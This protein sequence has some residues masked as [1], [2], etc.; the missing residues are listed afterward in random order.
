M[1]TML[2]PYLNYLNEKST[3]SLY[4]KLVKSGVITEASYYGYKNQKTVPKVNTLVK[5]LNV[6]NKTIDD[7]IKFINPKHYS[8]AYRSFFTEVLDNPIHLNVN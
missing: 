5:I 3:I 2:F 4:N 6:F 8:K 1:S 7:F